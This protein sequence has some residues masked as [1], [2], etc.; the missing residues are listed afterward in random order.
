MT[1]TATNDSKS[2]TE[3]SGI[4]C[5]TWVDLKQTSITLKVNRRA[6]ANLGQ[7]VIDCDTS[8][9]KVATARTHTANLSGVGHWLISDGFVFFDTQF[10][11]AIL[12]ENA[13]CATYM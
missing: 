5:P 4:S 8:P 1:A 13:T 9:I 12:T 3:G 6:Q 10:L 11:V 2:L 7:N